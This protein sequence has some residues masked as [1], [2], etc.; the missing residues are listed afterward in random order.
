LPTVSPRAK[1]I[2][3]LLAIAIV[4]IL[5]N[6]RVSSF[7]SFLGINELPYFVSILFTFIMFIVI[8]NGFNLIDGIDGLSAGVGILTISSLGI[9]FIMIGYF[10]YAV[11]CFSAVGALIAFT[12]FNVFGKQNKKIF[13]GDTGSLILGMMVTIFAIKF[14]ESSLTE[15]VASIFE[16]APSIIICMLIIPLIDTLRVFTLR[17]LVGTSPF[18]ADRFHTHHKLLLHGFSHLKITLIIL[19]FNLFVIIFSVLLR[20]LGNIKVLLI[21]F[22]TSILITS[23]PGLFFRYKVRRFLIKIDLLGDLSWI[24][25]ITFTKLIISYSSRIKYK[26]SSY[27][28]EVQ[29]QSENKDKNLDLILNDAYFKFEGEDKDAKELVDLKDIS[30]GWVESGS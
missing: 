6:I 7:H 19:A 16:S 27:L 3:E 13:L 25:P 11:F 18:K 9:W 15:T 4:V 17:I 21:V 14:L 12:R 5:G 24:L 30:N 2:A 1:L 8:I 23:I 29:N 22:P 28:D 10:S 26:R 20:N